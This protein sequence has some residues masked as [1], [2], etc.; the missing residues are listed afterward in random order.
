[1]GR[2]PPAGHS[3][4]HG[5]GRP[6]PQGPCLCSAAPRPRPYLRCRSTCPWPLASLPPPL[7]CPA[8]AESLASL[9]HLAGEAVGRHPPRQPVGVTPASTQ[10]RGDVSRPAQSPTSPSDSAARKGPEGAETGRGREGGM[11]LDRG[12]GTSRTEGPWGGR[13]GHLLRGPS[14]CERWRAS[15]PEGGPAAETSSELP[16]GHTG[17]PGTGWWTVRVGLQHGADRTHW[18]ER[19][20][21]LP[22]AATGSSGEPGTDK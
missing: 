10:T 11:G 9:S 18:T 21:S 22:R 8:G 14:A 15:R 5:P 20:T 19:K 16:R 6:R 7:R 1:M 12:T 13:A 4:Q 17:G 2:P 3:P